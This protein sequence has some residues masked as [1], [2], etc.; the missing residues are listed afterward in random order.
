[1]LISITKGLSY[2]GIQVSENQQET[3]VY[4]LRTSTQELYIISS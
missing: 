2:S 4:L 3:W 1:M